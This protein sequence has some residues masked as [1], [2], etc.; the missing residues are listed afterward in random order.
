MHFANA[1]SRFRVI[2]LSAL[3]AAGG[4]VIVHLSNCPHLLD[5]EPERLIS[6]TWQ[7]EEPRPFPATIK[8]SAKN[9]K[10][11]LA[12]I[13]AEIANSDVNIESL[14]LT[15][16]I[17]GKAEVDFTV[18]VTDAVHLYQLMDKIRKLPNILEAVRGMSD[19]V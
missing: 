6:V 18:E 7:N 2:R 15:S 1:A 5:L 9:E 3:S 4:G 13:S 16:T 8:V 10:G 14:I 12:S 19:Y 17:D 11:L